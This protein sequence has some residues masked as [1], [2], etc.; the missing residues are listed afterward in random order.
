MSGSTPG[1]MDFLAGAGPEFTKILLPCTDSDVVFKISGCSQNQSGAAVGSIPDTRIGV[2]AQ[3]R[4][5]Y[6]FP[7]TSVNLAYERF[8]TAGSGLFAGASSDIVRLTAARPLTRVWQGLL[9]T[10]Y[11]RNSRLQ[12]LSEKQLDTCNLAGDNPNLPA[13][14][15]A[16][17]NTYS[18]EF[19]GGALHRMF[20][21]TF[22]GF[23]SY[24]FNVLEFDHSYC[25]GLPEC[26]RTSNRQ[27]LT[28]GLDWVPRPVRLD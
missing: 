16:D 9:D 6:Q 15:G 2:A 21:R 1:R 19:V 28:I 4:L 23:V 27:V 17:A 7:K 24:Q 20:G 18:Y 10:G 25:A 8:D 5:R 12:P 13:C 3:G 11:S 22:H 26:N 14:P